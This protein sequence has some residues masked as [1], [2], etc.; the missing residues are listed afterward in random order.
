MHV[1]VA[2]SEVLAALWRRG[3]LGAKQLIAE[4][5]SA[6]PWGE[7]TNKT[8]LN[9]QMHKGAIRSVRDDGRLEYRAMLTREAYIDAEVQALADRLF[10]GDASALAA[11]LAGRGE[12]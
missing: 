4:V 5:R 3:P 7:A 12:P 10:A 6:Q 8:L 2:E 9:R 11:Y 1:T